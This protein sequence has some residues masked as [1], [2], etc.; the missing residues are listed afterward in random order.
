MIVVRLIL[1]ALLCAIILNACASQTASF[2]EEALTDAF[3]EVR[4]IV[5]VGNEKFGDARLRKA[6][7]TQQRP[8]L[9]PWKR[10]SDYNPS[11]V[12]ADLLRLQK[13]YFDRGYLDVRASVAKVEKDEAGNTVRLHVRIEEGEVT[14]VREVDI[15]V[16]G[17]MPPELPSAEALRN[18]LPLRVNEPIT[19][20]A[21]DASR[22]KVLLSLQ[23]AGYA[24]ATVQ[25][26]TEVDRRTHEAFV[27]YTLEAGEPTAFGQV[28]I[29]GAAN[30]KPEAIRRRLTFQPGDIY[31]PGEVADSQAAIYDLGMFRAVT[32]RSL[33]PEAAGEPLDIE[34]EVSERKPRSFEVGLG[35]STVE[36]FRVQVG[37]TFRNIFGGAQHLSLSG[38]A[39]SLG[40]AFQTRLHLPHLVTPHTRF[41]QTAFVDSQEEINTD[42]LGLTDR[43]FVVEDAQ[44]AFDVLRYGAESRVDHQFGRTFGA[45]LGV[46]LSSNTFSHVDPLVIRELGSEVAVDHFLFTQFAELTWNTSD[47]A[48]NATRGFLT[49]FRAEH[50]ATGI[51]SDF[52]FVKAAIEGRRYL[53]LWRRTTLAARLRLGV[54]QPYGDSE[55][56][57]FNVRFYAGGPGSIRGFAPNRVGP[58]A[59]DNAPLGGLSLIEGSMELRFSVVGELGGVL[60]VD[61][62][63]VFES[64]LEYH[65]EELRYAIGPGIRYNTPIGPVRFDVGFIIDRRP[66]EPFGRI[67]LSILQA[68]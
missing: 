46:E 62:G 4:S 21:F 45:A 16:E 9:S 37:W 27:R 44:P 22:D 48:I 19:K 23:R 63:Q 61:F 12:E 36:R 41:T 10:G 56:V 29:K 13:Y 50:S 31:S 18:G 17:P 39:S 20:A 55:V 11:A 38:K 24:R 43:I 15:R 60:F 64:S 32:P 40:T 33:N 47:R 8:L 52:D 67:E 58:L 51:L 42:P 68:F 7:A 49:V 66:D 2:R 57:P 3:P 35:L 1:T 54:V 6:M 30:V 59:A 26:H 53:P 5:F 65:L 14:V 25:P 28:T 34:F